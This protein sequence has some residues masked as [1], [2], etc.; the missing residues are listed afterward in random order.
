MAT[1]VDRRIIPTSQGVSH[2]LSIRADRGAEVE[3]AQNISAGIR[4]PDGGNQVVLPIKFCLVFPAR[5]G[6]HAE[7]IGSSLGVIP[8]K[9]DHVPQQ[10]HPSSNQ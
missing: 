3:I 10:T 7:K 5:D 8:N 4:P 9:A 2:V 1:T 6:Q